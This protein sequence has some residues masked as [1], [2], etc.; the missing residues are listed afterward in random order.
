MVRRL[1]PAVVLVVAL[2]SVAEAQKREVTV[3]EAQAQL[4]AE[5]RG[6]VPQ[7]HF[8]LLVVELNRIRREHGLREVRPNAELA[9]SAQSHAEDMIRRKFFAH[10]NPDG[11]N[12]VARVQRVTP[13]LIVMDLTEN[14]FQ[15]QMIPVDPMEERVRDAYIG[16]MESPGH[17]RN[18]LDPVPAEV[19]FGVARAVVD[20]QLLEM[21][22]QVFGTTYGT[23]EVMPTDTATA[24]SVWRAR[25]TQPLEFFLSDPKNPT[26]PYPDPVKPNVFW[27]GSSPMVVT[28]GENFTYSVRFPGV[29]DATYRMEIGRPG[30]NRYQYLRQV[31]VTASVK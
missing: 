7:R 12:H 14:L 31:R 17:R 4:R 23:W 20:N 22:V 1:A 25:L 18:L 28:R 10:D 3:L 26:R 11:E 6:P 19:G 27:R 30:E 8:D 2:A 24:G 21:V 5:T 29:P 16:W 9:R 15:T 13:K